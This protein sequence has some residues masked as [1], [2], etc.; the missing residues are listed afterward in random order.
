MTC[1][2]HVSRHITSVTE[3]VPA[4]LHEQ[5]FRIRLSLWPS[6]WP[7]VAL[8]V[9]V[10]RRHLPVPSRACFYGPGPEVCASR[11]FIMT[12][13]LFCGNVLLITLHE[14]GRQRRLSLWPKAPLRM[15]YLLQLPPL[16][17]G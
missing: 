9:Q 10:L 7:K 1:Y 12:Q 17:A 15:M 13:N 3:S 16:C 6:M 11:L 2:V 8:R 14:Q 4:M 5:G